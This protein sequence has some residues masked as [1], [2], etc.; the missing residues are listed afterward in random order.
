MEENIQPVN[1]PSE[2]VTP[3]PVIETKSGVNMKIVVILLSFIILL[4]CSA[5]AYVLFFKEEAVP[6]LKGDDAKLEESDGQKVEEKEEVVVEEEDIVVEEEKLK[7]KE[8]S[9]AEFGVKFNYPENWVVKFDRYDASS[10]GFTV[11]EN[12][13]NPEFV[14]ELIHPSASGPLFC[15]FKDYKGEDLDSPGGGGVVYNNYEVIGSNGLYRRTNNS[16]EGVVKSIRVCKLYD[17]KINAY[18]DD[19]NS[20]GTYVRYKVNQDRSDYKDML[21]ILD[22]ILLSLEFTKK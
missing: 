1:V 2:N 9:N 8:Y 6:V 22:N 20:N 14:F 11:S 4:L 18:I 21:G 13:T 10:F 3:Q 5:L 7:W 12:R 15:Y 17:S 16:E 19:V